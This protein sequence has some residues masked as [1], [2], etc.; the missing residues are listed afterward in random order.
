M[1]TMVQLLVLRGAL[2]L[3]CKGMVRSRR[4]SAYTMLKRHLGFRGSKQK[5]LEQTDA[6]IEEINEQRNGRA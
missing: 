3:E 2:R 1:M 6:L 5:V 4:P